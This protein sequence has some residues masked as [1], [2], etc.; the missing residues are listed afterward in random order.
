YIE[1]ALKLDHLNEF[2]LLAGLDIFTAQSNFTRLRE[3]AEIGIRN[4]PEEGP[5]YFYMS[6]A[7]MH[8][9]GMKNVLVYLEK[10]MELDPENETYVGRYAYILLK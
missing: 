8:L 9:E 6:E 3:I 10:A 4:Y 5:Y 7:V 2:V 1:E